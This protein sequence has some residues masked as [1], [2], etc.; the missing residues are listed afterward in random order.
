MG[1]IYGVMAY[2]VTR[3][4]REI[5]VRIALGATPGDVV[6]TV[7][8]QGLATVGIGAAAGILGAVGLTRG[9]RSMLYGVTPNDPVTFAGV[10][11]L[12]V[13]VASIA[14]WVPAR[15]GARV[16]PVEALRG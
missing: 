16:D 4:R 9:L 2:N 14:C 6:R 5:G 13:G 7:L 8:G 1:G 11:I 3:R 15:R 12:L 10:V